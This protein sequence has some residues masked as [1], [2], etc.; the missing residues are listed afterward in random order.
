MSRELDD[1]QLAVIEK[2]TSKSIA[3]EIY[4]A[5]GGARV[6]VGS[7]E[8]RKWSTRGGDF[9]YLYSEDAEMEISKD[10]R[11]CMMLFKDR[12]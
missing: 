9:V 5:V 8:S 12:H 7:S 10:S 2:G 11:K 3:D 1:N 4:L 6:L